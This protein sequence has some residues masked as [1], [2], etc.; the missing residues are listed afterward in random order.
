MLNILDDVV[1]R[2]QRCDMGSF[3]SR[4]MTMIERV[5]AE[6]CPNS[7]L[8]INPHIES[9]LKKWKKTIWDCL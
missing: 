3:K 5:L 9:K 8:K 1:A 6:M 4:T 2:G 7:S